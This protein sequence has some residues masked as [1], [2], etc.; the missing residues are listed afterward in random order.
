M[1]TIERT[2][3]YDL[4][5]SILNIPEILDVISPTKLEE[6][7]KTRRCDSIYYLLAKHEDELVG[8]FIVHKDGPCSY[9]IH[10][11]IPKVNRKEH[12]KEACD[13]VVQWVWGNIDT[14]KLN[15]EIPVIYQNVIN[16][17]LLT[18]FD[19]EGVKRKAYLK[20]GEEIDVALMG[21]VRS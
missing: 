6:P 1:I 19:I 12:S 3:D 5:D 16:R 15:A 9:K 11:N 8:L 17:S 20:D 4:V 14:N 18:G 21:I 2:K 10:A 7:Y 13:N